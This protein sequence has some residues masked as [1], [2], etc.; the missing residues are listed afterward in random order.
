MIPLTMFGDAVSICGESPFSVMGY[1]QL[2]IQLSRTSSQRGYRDS[3]RQ[4][5]HKIKGKK[6]IFCLGLQPFLSVMFIEMRHN[7]VSQSTVSSV[8][9]SN[10]DPDRPPSIS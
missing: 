1:S 3:M 10:P 6:G 4:D 8:S 9:F 5:F 7:G 2:S